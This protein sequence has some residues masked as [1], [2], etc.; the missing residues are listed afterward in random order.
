MRRS[1]L[2]LFL[3]SAACASLFLTSSCKFVDQ[4]KAVKDCK[5]ELK[6]VEVRDISLTDADLLVTLAVTNPNDLEVVVDRFSYKLWS[7]K[8]LIAEGWHRTTD[9]IPA[10]ETRDL[11]LTMHAP[12]KGLGK[13]V[14]DQ[15]R[16]R[17]GVTYTLQATVYLKTVVGEL[18]IPITVKKKY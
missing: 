1:A 10:G 16:N 5:F 2:N 4:R 9:K 3:A 14:L 13:G 12:L 11:A 6:D 7:D 17:A 15:L 8:H 18:E